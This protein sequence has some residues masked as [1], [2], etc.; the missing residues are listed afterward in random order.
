M[1][2]SMRPRRATNCANAPRQGV[3]L[4]QV[5]RQINYQPRRM[6]RCSSNPPHELWLVPARPTLAHELGEP[7]EPCPSPE[8][9]SGTGPQRQRTS[10]N[11][12][13]GTSRRPTN[14]HLASLLLVT[15]GGDRAG[16][17]AG[18]RAQR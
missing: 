7:R 15:T 18:N 4:L 6:R 10:M 17:L 1:T 11:C 5:R 9:L 16:H 3:T 2:F 14:S 13:A 12:T 8:G